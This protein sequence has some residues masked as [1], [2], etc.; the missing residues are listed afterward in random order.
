M[1]QRSQDGIEHI[2]KV[3]TDVLCQEAQ[4]EVAVLLQQRI[5]APVMAVGLGISQVLGT[6]QFDG[7][8]RFGT[9]QIHLHRSALVKGERELDIEPEL[10]GGFR[11]RF[12]PAKQERFRG[13]AGAVGAFG[14]RAWRAGG[15]NEQVGQRQVTAWNYRPESF[16]KELR[17][18]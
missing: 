15:A 2:V 11:Q 5:L 9:K 4:H 10:A 8:A 3:F 12:E 17:G 18:A 16:G 6:V 13:A 7:E 14:V 1:C